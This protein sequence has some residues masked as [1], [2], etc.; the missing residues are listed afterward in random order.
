MIRPFGSIR[1]ASP[2]GDPRIIMAKTKIQKVKA[3][4]RRKNRV[5]DRR[6]SMELDISATSVRRILKKR[7]ETKIL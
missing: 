4:L 2:L 5:S 6:Q 7:F 3:C 1:L